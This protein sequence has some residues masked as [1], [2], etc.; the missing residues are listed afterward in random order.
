MKVKTHRFHANNITLSLIKKCCVRIGFKRAN[1]SFLASE[2]AVD[3]EYPSVVAKRSS[4][5]KLNL[6]FI[7]LKFK[8]FVIYIFQ[9][10]IYHIWMNV[11]TNSKMIFF[12][13]S[14]IAVISSR[15]KKRIG[16]MEPRSFSFTVSSLKAYV[17]DTPLCFYNI[18]IV[19]SDLVRNFVG[20]PWR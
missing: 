6:T 12:P 3:F 15:L 10:F 9:S 20:I 1:D 2:C 14:N 16:L 5:P 8:I 17:L 13:Y 11:F 19:N 18:F 4:L 7:V